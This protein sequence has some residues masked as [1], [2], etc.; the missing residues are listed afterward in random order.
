MTHTSLKNE[1][2]TLDYDV[3]KNLERKVTRDAAE[4]YLA[5]IANAVAENGFTLD[6]LSIPF[7]QGESE[8][9]FF[10]IM[11]PHIEALSE[12]EILSAK[13]KT[14]EIFNTS[15]KDSAA[16]EF[17]HNALEKI[18]ALVIK[19]NYVQQI[20]F[21]ASANYRLQQFF[22]QAIKLVELTTP[23]KSE[24]RQARTTPARQ[25]TVIERLIANRHANR[26]YNP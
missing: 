17:A 24:T 21:K 16:H 25:L 4:L 1:P 19:A 18:E 22:H 11:M 12:A 5:N 14:L 8:D 7:F 13:E 20:N 26:P 9:S 10:E 3:W 6:L 2:F 23:N 15:S